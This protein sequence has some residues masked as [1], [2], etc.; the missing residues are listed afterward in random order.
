MIRV[1]YRD[2]SS[3]RFC[4]VLH[5]RSES[6]LLSAI[7]SQVQDFTTSDSVCLCIG[8]VR[9]GKNFNTRIYCAPEKLVE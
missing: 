4:I 3:R 9:K 7:S 1:L 6:I 8:I 5:F 2:H